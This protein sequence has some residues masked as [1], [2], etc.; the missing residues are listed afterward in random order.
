MILGIDPGTKRVG[1]AIA[2]LETRFARPLAI[3]EA[4]QAE[5]RILELV[6]EHAVVTVV[7]GRPV[8]LSG[9]AGPAVDN[10]EGFVERL[11]S[12]LSD[13][14]ELVSFDERLTSIVASQGLRAAGL[15]EKDARGK[16][17]AVAAQVLLQGYLDQ[18]GSR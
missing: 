4:D 5:A 14:V 10:L 11:R 2:D 12:A 8:G 17:D 3:V 6:E 9:T 1:I 18:T 13:D 16:I 7:V 15:S